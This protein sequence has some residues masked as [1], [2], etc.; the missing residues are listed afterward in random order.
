MS[1]SADAAKENVP[2]GRLGKGQGGKCRTEQHA[3]N[4]VAPPL[5]PSSGDLREALGHQPHP[6][7]KEGESAQYSRCDLN[8]PCHG[9]FSSSASLEPVKEIEQDDD[10]NCD[11]DFYFRSLFVIHGQS[12]VRMAILSQTHVRI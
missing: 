9:L 3:A 4:R 11:Y 5:H 1:A 8:V 6:I 7:N 12:S 10:G 2:H